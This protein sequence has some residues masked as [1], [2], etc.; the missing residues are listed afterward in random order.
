MIKK[1]N[2]FLLF[3]VYLFTLFVVKQAKSNDIGDR[4]VKYANGFIGTPY[5]RIPIGLY[6]KEKKLIVDNEMDCMY[7]VFR[8]ISLALAKGDNNKAQEIACDKMFNDKCIFDEKG[9]VSNYQNRFEYSED[10]IASGKW[11]KSIFNKNEMSK[12]KGSRMYKEFS[13]VK[14]EDIIGNKKLQKK[15]KNGDIL[16]LYKHPEK[17]SKAQEA[18]GHLGILEVDKKT[19]NIYFIHASGNKCFKD[20]CFKQR[21][22]GAVKKVL[23]NEYLQ[24]KKDKFV[25]IDILR[26]K[27]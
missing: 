27:K 19:K 4:I 6:V 17:R 13:Y 16:F 20:E 21:N 9:F 25:G 14:S 24:E 8:T 12:L 15:I 3:I 5:D 26:I 11:G 7:F 1:Q 10:M 23:L 22:Q 18:I 2:F